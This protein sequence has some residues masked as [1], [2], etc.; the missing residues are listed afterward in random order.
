MKKIVRRLPF[1]K[2]LPYSFYTRLDPE[3][4]KLIECMK[5]DNLKT[6]APYKPSAL[7]W[8]W[9]SSH[10]E[11]QIHIDGPNPENS[12]INHWFA[13]HMPGH[14]K[15]YFF[16]VWNLYK[17]LKERDQFGVFEKVKPSATKNDQ[18][19]IVIDDIPLSWDYL[20]SAQSALGLLE[21]APSL[22]TENK[23]ILE[24][25]AGWGR[26]AH[27]MTTLN[28]QLNYI[29]ADIPLTLFVAQQYL[30]KILPNNIAFNY[31]KTRNMKQIDDEILKEK[32]GIS[33]IGTHCIPLIQP[34]TVDLS[35]N[36]ASFQEMELENIELYMEDINRF[37]KSCY[38]LQRKISDQASFDFYV[39]VSNKFNWKKRLRRETEFSPGYEEAF[40][41]I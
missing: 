41:D 5:E 31:S 40:F 3:Q 36:I 21:A 28:P 35:I 22:L 13:S 34:N 15:Y 4:I 23:T 38:L 2:K 7:I 26:L 19:L 29:I 10:L 17:R 16:A 11:K 1:Y 39:K 9:L 32:T 30:S 25:G 37:S 27:F 33:F 18:S 6:H 14:K 12:V 20:L 24:I 8:E